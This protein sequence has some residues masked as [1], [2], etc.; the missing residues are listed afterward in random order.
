MLASVSVDDVPLANFDVA[1]SPVVS[2]HPRHALAQRL[3][4]QARVAGLATATMQHGFD[5]VGISR[6]HDIGSSAA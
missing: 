4:R 1:L 6:S 2:S 3:M 5:S